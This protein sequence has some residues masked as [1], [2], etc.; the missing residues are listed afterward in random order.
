MQSIFNIR[1]SYGLPICLS[2]ITRHHQLSLSKQIADHDRRREEMKRSRKE[3]GRVVPVNE[4][5]GEVSEIE[6]GYRSSDLVSFNLNDDVNNDNDND[7]DVDDDQSS[8]LHTP[9]IAKAA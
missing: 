1:T 2:G 3:N 4:I 6:A 8:V 7:D 5:D 9:C